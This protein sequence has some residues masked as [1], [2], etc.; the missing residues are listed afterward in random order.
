V[1]SLHSAFAVRFQL[2][3]TSGQALGLRLA[4]Y[5]TD[6]RGSLTDRS[7]R[8]C[9]P[10]RPGPRPARPAGRGR[11]LAG[12]PGRARARRGRRGA[13]VR[14]C[15]RDGRLVGH[16]PRGLY[17][18]PGRARDAGRMGALPQT[19]SG[20]GPIRMS[21]DPAP[22]DAPRPTPR[23]DPAG[24]S[25]QAPRACCESPACPATPGTHARRVVGIAQVLPQTPSGGAPIR[26][27]PTL[28]LAIARTSRRGARP[29]GERRYFHNTP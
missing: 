18:V 24:N 12:G 10:G 28:R 14:C 15:A 17:G 13:V 8:S 23:A 29:S 5:V 19:P 16:A 6:W 25:V 7:P 22:R 11:C 3:T 27:R 21:C 26:T 4:D 1:G 2:A 20:G 9:A